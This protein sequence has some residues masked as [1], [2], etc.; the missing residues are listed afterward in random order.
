V[1]II[2]LVVFSV[3][4]PSIVGTTLI[5][6]IPMALAALTTL[7]FGVETKKRRLEEITAEEFR[8]RGA[9]VRLM[10]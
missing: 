9:T 8:G 5:G 2:A 4:P 7:L 10:P 1:V 3:A 6:G